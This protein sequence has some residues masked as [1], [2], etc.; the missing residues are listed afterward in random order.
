MHGLKKKVRCKKQ[1]KYVLNKWWDEQ[2]DLVI[3]ET[4]EGYR[5]TSIFPTAFHWSWFETVTVPEGVR[6]LGDWV[7][8]RCNNLTSISL[9]ERPE[10]IGAY[11]FWYDDSLTE[12]VVPDGVE[13]I[14]EGAF[15]YCHA[16]TDLTLPASLTGISDNLCEAAVSLVNVNIPD[17]VKTIGNY[18]FN[19]CHELADISIPDGVEKIGDFAFHSCGSAKK[20][21]IPDSVTEIGIDAFRDC[22][23]VE[24][25][26]LSSSIDTIS[27]YAFADCPNLEAVIVH[28]GVKN[29]GFA[30]FGI[31]TIDKYHV[32]EGKLFAV[33]LPTTIESIDE[34]AFANNGNLTIYYAGT[35][36]QWASV[37]IA[38]HN[39]EVLNANVVFLGDDNG[40]PT[41]EDPVDSG[42]QTVAGDIN[43]DGVVNSKDLTRFIKYLA[44]QD[45]TV[46]EDTLDTTGDGIV[47]TKDLIRLLK[48][49]SGE[50]VS[51]G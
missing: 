26:E 11:E 17:G 33:I 27:P 29:I 8:G 18:A 21:I 9:P 24:E 45:V 23:D 31:V 6:D 30:A 3:P 15:A 42:Q 38:D 43:G 10:K 34:Y 41:G 22:Q 20:I 19:C 50:S 35:E 25:L 47:N 1:V 13:E 36:E 14:G 49:L 48:Y 40:D 51:I 5:V 12:V 16:L 44:G 32:D 39:E 4:I 37:E 28:D 2:Y 7:F 46:D